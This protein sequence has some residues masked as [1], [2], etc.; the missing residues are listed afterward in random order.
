MKKILTAVLVMA[1]A[2]VGFAA[3]A[4]KVVKSVVKKT[5]AVAVVKKGPLLKNEGKKTA[6]KPAVKAAVRP[7]VRKPAKKANGSKRAF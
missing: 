1:L 2:G 7:A 4:K 3:P 5:A 6:V